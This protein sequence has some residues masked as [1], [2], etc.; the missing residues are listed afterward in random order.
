M[1]NVVYVIECT[2]CVLQCTKCAI[3]YVGETKNALHIWM[4][5]HQSDIKN[6][7]LEKLVAKHFNSIGH[8]LDDLSIFVV[9]KIYWEDPMFRKDKGSYMDQ[10]SPVAGPKGTE[11]WSIRS[12]PCV[13]LTGLLEHSTNRIWAILFFVLGIIRP[14]APGI[15]KPNTSLYK[16]E[17]EKGTSPYDIKRS[18]ACPALASITLEEG[19]DQAEKSR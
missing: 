2:K 4:S 14:S 12:L 9:E 10:T 16:G 15:I 8:S 13:L 11:P 1:T 7:H 17:N 3:Q 18:F 19:L 6:Q 5:G